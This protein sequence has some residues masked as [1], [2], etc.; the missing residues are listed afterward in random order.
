MHLRRPA[1]ID[2]KETYVIAD[3]SAAMEGGDCVVTIKPNQYTGCTTPSCCDY[4]GPGQCAEGTQGTYAT[5]C[6]APPP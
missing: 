4:S 5:G 3:I 6:A 2:L 1:E